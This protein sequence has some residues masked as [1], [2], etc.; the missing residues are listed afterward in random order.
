MGRSHR[1]GAFRTA[2][3]RR[4]GRADQICFHAPGAGTDMPVESVLP[5]ASA[6]AVVSC[7]PHVTPHQPERSAGAEPLADDSF[8]GQDAAGAM[9]RAELSAIPLSIA[10]AIS[11]RSL[12]NQ[13]NHLMRR[14]ETAVARAL[15]AS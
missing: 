1:G 10:T 13:S 4:P 9:F 8:C 5:A 15:A 12:P 14:V 11:Q 2:N 3:R 6:I 7:S